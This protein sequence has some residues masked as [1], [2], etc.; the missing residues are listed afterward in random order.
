MCESQMLSGM[1]A[2]LGESVNELGAHSQLLPVSW[3]TAS[4]F[5]GKANVVTEEKE[6][7]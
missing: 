3:V 2:V 4:G 6:E 7:I 5:P 1:M